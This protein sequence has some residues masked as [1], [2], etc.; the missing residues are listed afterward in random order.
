MYNIAKNCFAW[1]RTEKATVITKKRGFHH[2]KRRTLAVQR[3]FYFFDIT[4]MK[5]VLSVYV[6]FKLKKL[7]HLNDIKKIKKNVAQ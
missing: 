7:F 6:F 1:K 4:F 3:S 5:K 2:I